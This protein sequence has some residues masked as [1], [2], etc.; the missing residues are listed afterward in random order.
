VKVVDRPTLHTSADIKGIPM[1]N[2]SVTSSAPEPLEYWHPWHVC[3]AGRVMSCRKLYYVGVETQFG[4][5]W[6]APRPRACGN[7]DCE[8][9]AREPIAKLLKHLYSILMPRA[10]VWV[11]RV[12]EPGKARNNLG[13]TVAQ[14][15][16][17][18][19]AILAAQ[20]LPPCDW[21]LLTAWDGQKTVVS[22]HDLSGREPE[23]AGTWW[24]GSSAFSML[25]ITVARV[26]VL[27]KWP[28]FRR[29]S[30]WAMK[31]PRPPQGKGHLEQLGHFDPQTS[32]RHF[33]SAADEAE[34]RWGLRPVDGEPVPPAVPVAEWIEVLKRHHK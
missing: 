7:L 28:S 33:Q 15:A 14:R 8:Q 12:R 18:L 3:R 2:Q 23:L 30:P 21:I 1:S 20:G 25:R 5:R 29:G 27:N 26:G 32:L 9:C 4:A 10:S 34:R 6:T 22:T 19:S 31:R 16:R 24:S 13:R 17:R 11:V